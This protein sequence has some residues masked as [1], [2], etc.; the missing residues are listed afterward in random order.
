MSGPVNPN[1]EQSTQLPGNIIHGYSA[2]GLSGHPALLAI[3][4]KSQIDILS[5]HPV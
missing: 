2:H 5:V 4:L 3:F 1:A